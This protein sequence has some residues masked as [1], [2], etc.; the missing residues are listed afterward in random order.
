MAKENGDDEVYKSFVWKF[1]NQEDSEIFDR[2]R[3]LVLR[4]NCSVELKLMY[5]VQS[6]CN[7]ARFEPVPVLE[8][9]VIDKLAEDGIEITRVS[10]KKYRDKGVLLDEEN[11]AF[12]YTDGHAIAYDY[13]LL[14]DFIVNRKLLGVEPLINETT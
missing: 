1:M 7:A 4:Q 6:Y 14:K 2:F 9:Q 12:W 5:M 10:L 11:N 13:D 8:A 3:L